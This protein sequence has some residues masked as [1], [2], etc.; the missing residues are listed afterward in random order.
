MASCGSAQPPAHGPQLRVADLKLHLKTLAWALDG[1]WAAQSDLQLA[2]KNWR[3]FGIRQPAQTECDRHDRSAGLRWRR[4]F[5]LKPA[6]NFIDDGR[7][8]RR[9]YLQ[10]IRRAR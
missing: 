3:I 8:I 7:T 9:N 2:R 5:K 4:E 1:D 10:A 6:F